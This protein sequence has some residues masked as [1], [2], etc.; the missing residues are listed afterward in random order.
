MPLPQPSG[1]PMGLI[2]VVGGL[3][4]SGR[5]LGF[6]AIL[7]ILSLFGVI[8]RNAVI[9][10]EQSEARARRR[11]GALARRG[12]CQEV[13]LP[14]DHAHRHLDRARPNPDRVYDLLGANGHR[15]HGRAAG[16][17]AATRVPSVVWFRGSE[18]ALADS[19]PTGT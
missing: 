4:D 12:R 16:C 10:I 14:L 9:L 6:M 1:R 5:P 15:D 8:T 17:Q 18:M 7:G 3:L 2:G 13:T 11:D 19:A